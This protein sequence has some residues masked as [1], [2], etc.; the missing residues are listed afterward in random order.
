M[1]MRSVL[2][3]LAALTGC[4]VGTSQ[5]PSN[6]PTVLSPASLRVRFQASASSAPGLLPVDTTQTGGWTE[7]SPWAVP[8]GGARGY[9]ITTDYSV[10]CAGGD[11]LAGRVLSSSGCA[12]ILQG[13]TTGSPPPDTVDAAE[14][15]RNYY[16]AFTAHPLDPTD[17]ESP[18]LMFT[19]GE[20]KNE[21]QNG[22]VYTN[23]INVGV[24]DYSGYGPDGYVDAW[25]AYNGFVGSAILANPTRLAVEAPAVEDAGPVVWPAAGYLTANG[26]KASEGVRHPSSIVYDGNIYL[27]YL[28]MSPAGDADRPPGIKVARAAM[29]DAGTPGSFSVY[30]NGDFTEPGLPDGYTEW[31][32]HDSLS[33]PGPRSTAILGDDSGDDC[34]FSVARVL[35]SPTDGALFLGVEEHSDA[36]TGWWVALRLSTNL[37]DWSPR[38]F[39][40]GIT[41]S[42]WDSGFLHYP[43]LMDTGAQTN[44]TIAPD[45]FYVVGTTGAYTNLLPLSI[46]VETAP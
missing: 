37:T 1:P 20:N 36:D 42:D 8:V 26:A 39:I 38:Y 22:N 18:L 9:L 17:P 7:T 12:R 46:T 11:S 30:Y 33:Q 5:P 6:P 2:V 23:T 34:R 29:S 40:P 32:F 3:V 44:N 24:T 19:H 21:I 41:A 13:G 25:D 4:T 28:D 10:M 35:P 43:L 31:T 14:W 16:G 15:R 45:G 27:F